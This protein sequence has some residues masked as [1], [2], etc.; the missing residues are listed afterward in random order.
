MGAAL[1][2]I[3]FSSTISM[4]GLSPSIIQNRDLNERHIQTANT[5][6]ILLGLFF[7]LLIFFLAGPIEAFFEMTD[8][9]SII[10]W[11]AI[12]F[13]FQGFGMTSTALMERNMKFKQ[14]SFIPWTTKIVY[15]IVSIVMA[16]T[17]WGV[18]AL[19][20]GRLSMVFTNNLLYVAMQPIV[21]KLRISR[22]AFRDL[23]AFGSGMSLNRLVN[24]FGRQGDF[25]LVGKFMG[26]E[27][28]GLYSKAFRLMN[29]PVSFVGQSL[30]NILLPALSKVQ[31][32][33]AKLRLAFEKGINAL[34]IF[35][36]PLTAFSFVFSREIVLIIL[37]QQWTGAILPFQVLAFGM[38]FR[39][40]YKVSISIISAKGKSYDLLYRM[41]I[42]TLVVLASVFIAVG[43]SLAAVA[44]AMLFSLIILYLLMSFGAMRLI[45]Y[46]VVDFIKLHIR[47]VGGALIVASICALI[48]WAYV[49]MNL[50]QLVGVL[51]SLVLSGCVWGL[52]YM[53]YPKVFGNYE[54][55]FVNEVG[56]KLLKK[57]R[58]KS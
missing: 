22:S 53:K 35:G 30:Q 37:G 48:K 51:V 19:V 12:I 10:Q 16:L 44:A 36:L 41:I 45:E 27:A 3:D 56:R 8:L 55:I 31:Q 17:G 15:G 29:L 40:G 5:S 57:L 32:D 42:F 54:D 28:L 33:N 7:F 26:S 6:G 21:P 1:L 20:A 4:M 39:I 52:M 49:T 46:K 58:L 34:L 2:I 23:F 9:K 38:F 43:I 24:Y 18:Y 14:I 25:L 11:L 13:L 47:P 50:H